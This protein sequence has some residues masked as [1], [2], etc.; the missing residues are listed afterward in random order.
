MAV[1]NDCRIWNSN[2]EQHATAK[3]QQ[4][5]E[6]TSEFYTEIYE[7]KVLVVVNLK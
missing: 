5:V 6:K 4:I 2:I 7:R 1:L 3:T